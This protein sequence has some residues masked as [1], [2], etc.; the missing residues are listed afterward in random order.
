VLQD[1]STPS[2]KGATRKGNSQQAGPASWGHTFFILLSKPG[3]PT[4]HPKHLRNI[5]CASSGG[6]MFWTCL[7]EPLTSFLV[8]N[9][10]IDTEVQKAVPGIPGCLEHSWATF[11]A[12]KDAKLNKRQICVTMT[13]LKDAYGSVKHNLLQF[14]MKWYRIPDWYATLAFHYYENLVAFVKTNEWQTNP[15]RYGKVFSKAVSSQCPGSP[16][17]HRLPACPRHSTLHS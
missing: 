7:L 17:C 10:Y 12:L 1:C 9:K 14:A 15:F 8:D 2:A 3:K 5:A 13:D 4:D 11:E 16:N 6:K